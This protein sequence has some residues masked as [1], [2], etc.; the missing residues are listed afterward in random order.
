MRRS[1]PAGLLLALGLGA[2]GDLGALRRLGDEGPGLSQHR[3]ADALRVGTHVP[4]VGEVEA[5]GALAERVRRGTPAF[6]GLVRCTDPRV[7]FKDEEGTGADRWMTPRL[8]AKVVPLGERVRREWPGVELRVTEAWDEDAEHGDRSLHYE[9]RAADLT[10]SDLDPRKL[11][12]LAALA[13]E[14]GFGWVYHEPTHV[15]VSVPR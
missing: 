6:A 12:R 9:G 7:V 1:G 2:C 8:R 14:G 3:R 13:V 15:H 10:T 4:P 5:V 11:G